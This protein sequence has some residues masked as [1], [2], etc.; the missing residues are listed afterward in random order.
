[1]N[2]YLDIQNIYGFR[3]EEDIL[4]LD[5][6]DAEQPV[7][8]NPTDPFNEQRY[9]TKFITTENGTTLPTIGIIVEI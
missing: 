6:D 4:I 2:L 8:L 7:I 5:K 1:M 3:T 9:R